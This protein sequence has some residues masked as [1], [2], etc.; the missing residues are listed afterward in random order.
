M[1]LLALIPARGGSKG[2]PRKNIRDLQG[3]P[4]LAWSIEA[5]IRASSVDRIMVSTEDQEIAD[6]ARTWGADVPFL[7]PPELARDDTPGIEPVL[8]ALSRLPGY[9][10]VL[11]LQPTSPLRTADDIEGIIRLCL[12]H[13]APAA[14]SVCQASKHP[15]WMYRC[16]AEHRLIPYSDKPLVS[17]RQDLPPVYALNGALYLARCDWLLQRRGFIAEETLGYEMPAN[18]SADIDSALDWQWVEFLMG[19]TCSE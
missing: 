6:V 16:G 14:V 5:A 8:H 2:V 17:R 13:D 4:L 11:L 19:K 9:D 15:Q 12:K 10:W 1:K 3:R 18:R 7:R